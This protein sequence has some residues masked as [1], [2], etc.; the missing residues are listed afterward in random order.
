MILRSNSAT[1]IKTASCNLPKG[2]GV[3]GCFDPLAGANQARPRGQ[4]LAERYPRRPLHLIVSCRM[5]HH[6]AGKW[7]TALISAREIATTLGS[8]TNIKAEVAVA[9]KATQE[10]R[11]SPFRIQIQRQ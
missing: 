5:R 6:L 7:F 11:L 8:V 4:K 9:R 2:L 3:V 10:F 1:A